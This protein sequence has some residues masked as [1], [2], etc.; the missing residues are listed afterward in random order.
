M[1]KIQLL[2]ATSIPLI[3]AGLFNSFDES[4]T[5]L[6]KADA[7]WGWI[8]ESKGTNADWKPTSDSLINWIVPMYQAYK[9]TDFVANWY[10]TG[11][12]S[13]RRKT[14]HTKG[15]LQKIRYVNV[16]GH[17]YTGLFA[18]DNDYGLLRYSISAKSVYLPGIAF[19][20]YRDGQPSGNI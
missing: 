16:G 17:S 9:P 3:S 20:F 13:P 1:L 12:T 18:G 11:W 5:A 4:W 19:K 10:L 8:E 15:A 6:E 7:I 14:V 2:I